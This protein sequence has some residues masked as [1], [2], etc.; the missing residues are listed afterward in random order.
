MEL[1]R[2]IDVTLYERTKTGTDDFNAPLYEDI[3]V[4]VHNV[5][6]SPTAAE[7]VV[8]DLQLHG[9]RSEYELCIPKDDAHTWEDCRVDFLGQSW[10]VFGPVREYIEANVPLAWNRKVRVERYG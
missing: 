10:R 6:V 3:P 8:N 4:T 9:K 2:G 5:L 7:D 1:I